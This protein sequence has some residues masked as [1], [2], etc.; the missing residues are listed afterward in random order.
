M[1]TDV[2]VEL[3]IRPLHNGSIGDDVCQV[4]HTLLVSL[5]FGASLPPTICIID[6]HTCKAARRLVVAANVA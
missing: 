5:A 1:R 3:S 2:V 4:V 6:T